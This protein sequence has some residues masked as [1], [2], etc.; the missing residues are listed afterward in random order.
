MKLYLDFLG[1]EIFCYEVV[2]KISLNGFE[3]LQDLQS[4]EWENFK[5]VTILPQN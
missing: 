2:A 4:K 5:E 1:F 3:F